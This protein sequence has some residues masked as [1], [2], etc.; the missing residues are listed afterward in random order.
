MGLFIPLKVKF[1]QVFSAI[2]LLKR[3]AQFTNFQQTNL[4]CTQKVHINLKAF[5]N[6]CINLYECI[7]VAIRGFL[8]TKPDL[9]H[10]LLLNFCV[11]YSRA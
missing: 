2:S 1:V 3:K 4:N 8:F 6:K 10:V 9:I 7:S 5:I 11:F